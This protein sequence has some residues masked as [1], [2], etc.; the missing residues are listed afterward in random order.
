MRTQTFYRS[1]VRM[2]AGAV[3]GSL[4]LSFTALAQ[5]VEERLAK[6]EAA[7]ASAQTAGDNAWLLTSSALVLLMTGPGLAL[8]YGGLV[9]KKN[10]LATMMQSFILMVVVTVIWAIF[11]YSLAFAKGSPFI[12]G[13][14]YLFMKGVGAAPSVYA[15]TI[16]HQTYMVFQLMFAIITPALITGAFAERMKFSAMLLFCSLW[17]VV[18]YF[19]LAHMV[20]G[21]GGYLNAFLGGKIPALDFAGGTVVH[22]SSGF[23]ALACAIYLGKRLGYPKTIMAPHNLVIS[24]IG[25]CLLW[26]GWFGFNAGSAV[27]AGGLASSAFVATHFGAASAVAGWLIIEW[28]RNGKPTVLGGVSGAVVGLVAITPASGFVTPMA[29]LIIGFVAG[30]VC[31]FAVTSLKKALGYDDSLDAFGV[32]GIG[33]FTGAILTGVFANSAVNTV[34]KDANGAALPSGLIEGNSKQVLNQLIAS[35]IA[36]GLTMVASFIILKVVDLIVGVRVS[37]EDEVTGLDLSQHGEEGYNLGLDAAASGFSDAS[38]KESS[39][40]A[41]AAEPSA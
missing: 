20:W 5:T 39:F 34:F 17:A 7:L 13:L 36:I 14:D 28:I 18:V 24:V 29:A 31:Y 1:V 37:G 11:G 27:A 10:V 6:A 23:S 3:F 32:H 9:R 22:I 21:D 16:P 30:I 41:A 26:V 2:F 38:Y 40:A 4:L 35:L 12:G 15:G 19:P 33:G 25:A 8:F